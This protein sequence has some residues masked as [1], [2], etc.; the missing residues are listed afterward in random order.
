MTTVTVYLKN[1]LWCYQTDGGEMACPPHV[2]SR[3]GVKLFFGP[4]YDVVF[5][6]ENRSRVRKIKIE[7][8]EW[9]DYEAQAETPMRKPAGISLRGRKNRAVAQYELSGRFLRTWDSCR[10]A[11]ASV[12]C[13]RTTLHKCCSGATSSAYGFIWRWVVDGKYPKRV[14]PYT[15]PVGNNGRNRAVVMKDLKGNV[16]A[17]YGSIMEAARSCGLQS[18]TL[19]RHLIVTKTPLRGRIWE[20]AG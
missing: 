1:G 17:R 10:T 20:F 18:R 15:K 4:D 19:R 12:G 5:A 14:E 9:P 8:G 3:E 7:T 13:E 6:C 2:Y 16:L 11:A